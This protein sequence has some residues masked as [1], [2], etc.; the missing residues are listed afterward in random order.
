MNPSREIK[1][2]EDCAV[3][4][5]VSENSSSPLQLEWSPVPQTLPPD[6]HGGWFSPKVWLALSDGTVSPG[7]CLHAKKGSDFL[8]HSWFANNQQIEE[9][10]VQVVAW[11]PFAVPDHPGWGRLISVKK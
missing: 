10:K 5:K 1:P 2:V 4:A 11:M 8:V 7:E 9:D 3:N 6:P